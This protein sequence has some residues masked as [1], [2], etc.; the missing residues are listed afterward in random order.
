MSLF[1]MLPC[2]YQQDAT[3]TRVTNEKFV[4]ELE[5]NT[6]VV[7]MPLQLD[8]SMT[9]LCLTAD[10]DITLDASRHG[11]WKLCMFAWILAAGSVHDLTRVF[12]PGVLFEES[13]P[14]DKF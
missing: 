12:E 4:K 2:C 3:L 6:N 14:M 5:F 10:G 11:T 9:V 1:I 7:S 8:F 13:H